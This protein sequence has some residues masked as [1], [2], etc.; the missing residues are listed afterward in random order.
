[1]IGHSRAKRWCHVM[2]PS[3]D[4][5]LRCAIVTSWWRHM[6]SQFSAISDVMVTP[7]D[8]GITW[9]FLRESCWRRRRLSFFVFDEAFKAFSLINKKLLSPFHGDHYVFLVQKF[10]VWQNSMF[11]SHKRHINYPQ[12]GIECF[13]KVWLL[14]TS[15]FLEITTIMSQGRW[16]S[17]SE[18]LSWLWLWTLTNRSV[19]LWFSSWRTS[20]YKKYC[21]YFSYLLQKSR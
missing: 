5:A 4:V 15:T 8:S 3:C 2:T 16:S 14:N 20:K 12:E 17:I 21:E 1:M 6:T 10:S 7:H 19:L 13:S 9:R 11:N 18:I